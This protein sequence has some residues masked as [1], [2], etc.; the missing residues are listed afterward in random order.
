MRY[1]D[2][3]EPPAAVHGPV[4]AHRSN[5]EFLD[6]GLSAHEL[7]ESDARHRFSWSDTLAPAAAGRAPK[8]HAFATPV[9]VTA[10]R[11]RDAGT[12]VMMAWRVEYSDQIPPEHLRGWHDDYSDARPQSTGGVT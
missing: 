11:G 8:V 2:L 1:L 9:P 6:A 3:L 4:A 7:P 12:A 10:G 5:Q